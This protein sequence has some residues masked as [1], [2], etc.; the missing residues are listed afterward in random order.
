MTHSDTTFR[1]NPILQYREERNQKS[2]R[3]F[4]SGE[5]D[6]RVAPELRT[7]LHRV[8]EEDP[9]DVAINLADVPF[10]DSSGVATLVEAQR[11]LMR[12]EKK[13]RLENPSDAVRYTLKITQLLRVFGL[14]EDNTE[15]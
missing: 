5:V 7:L 6:M 8:I 13:L 9:T 2:V 1:D 11:L 3:L 14:E 12:K 4:L 15:Q 10:I